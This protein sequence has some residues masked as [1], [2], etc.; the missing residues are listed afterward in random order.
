MHELGTSKDV[1]QGLKQRQDSG[2][3]ESQEYLHSIQS[4][5]CFDRISRNSVWTKDE[6][7]QG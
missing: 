5:T 3:G 2:T 1:R 6:R 7:D 4:S